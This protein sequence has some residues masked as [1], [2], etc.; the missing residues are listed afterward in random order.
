MSEVRTRVRVRVRGRSR[1][2]V[3]VRTTLLDFRPLFGRGAGLAL[4]P[5]GEGGKGGGGS[6]SVSE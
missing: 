2:R 5:W 4:Q 1:G 6:Q 3:R